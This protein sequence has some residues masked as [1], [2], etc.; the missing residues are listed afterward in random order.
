MN[1][2]KKYLRAEDFKKTVE[3]I[4]G[5]EIVKMVDNNLL[6]QCSG[7]SNLVKKQEER[8]VVLPS[9]N[10][11]VGGIIGKII[12]SHES[13]GNYNIFNRGTV[14]KV[15]WTGG[16]EDISQRTVNEWIELGKLSGD[17]WNK[18]F[19]MGKYQIIPDTL[20]GLK[21]KFKLTGNE[22]ITNELQEMF[23]LYYIYSLNI[24][25]LIIKGDPSLMDKVC[26]E[27]AKIW[28]SVGVPYA[29]ERRIKNKNKEVQTIAIPKGGSF[30]A[31]VGGNKAHTKP[32]DVIDALKQMNKDYNYLIGIGKSSKEAFDMLMIYRSTYF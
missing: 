31:G 17:D 27:I 32:E 21:K 20:S 8:K 30:W 18:R 10:K 7:L 2:Y 28:A 26:L 22:K 3:E 1:S 4:N 5:L 12:A 15:K 13:K 6:L 14:G 16:T 25:N 23:F 9:T 11:S 19:A 29:T 24:K